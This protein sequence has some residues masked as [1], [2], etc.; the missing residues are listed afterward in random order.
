MK[1]TILI[2]VL[3]IG[4][5]AVG[6]YAFSQNR[7]LEDLQADSADT[8]AE[9]Q[10]SSTQSAGDVLANQTAFANSAYATT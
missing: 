7:R 2:I 8:I 4:I 9:L 10:A 1:R 5:A 3:L 6:Y